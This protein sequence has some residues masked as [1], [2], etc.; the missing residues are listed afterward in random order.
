ME[1]QEYKVVNGISFH[2]DTPDKVCQILAYYC[3]DRNQRVRIFLGD[4]ET[5]KD[6]MEVWQTVGYIGRST[7]IY[8]IPLML[9][10]KDS[11]GGG[12][13]L[14]NCIVKITI[15]KHVVYQHPN[16]HCPI[17]KRGSEIWDA[18][19]NVCI[20]RRTDGNIAAVEREFQF[21]L[22]NRNAH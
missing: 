9:L 21:F 3:G 11:S 19:K 1:K 2:Q 17:E 20:F 4:K 14:D 10:R 16:Y 12:A 7:G 18:E 22:G 8:K 6:W 13:I 15:D 5:G